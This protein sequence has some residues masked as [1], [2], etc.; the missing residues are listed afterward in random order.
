MFFEFIKCSKC[1]NHLLPDTNET[2]EEY[3]K[4]EFNSEI[5]QLVNDSSP[6]EIPTYLVYRCI[7]TSCD[8]VEKISHVDLLNKVSEG[9]AKFARILAQKELLNTFKF[10]E[11]FTRYI[12]DRATHD[13]ITK[14]DLERNLVIKELFDLVEKEEKKND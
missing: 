4:K 2:I 11:Y 7:N 10:K 14:K 6:I 5:L 9:L 12:V 3:K 8:N 1:G 13:I